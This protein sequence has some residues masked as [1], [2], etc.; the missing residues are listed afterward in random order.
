MKKV[1]AIISIILVATVAK[2]EMFSNL[3]PATFRDINHGNW[4]FGGTTNLYKY[5]LV[6][7]DAGMIK[8]M[9]NN[10]NLF[11]IGGIMFYGREL[12]AK[13]QNLAK[14]SESINFDKNL[15]Q[16]INVGLWGGKDFDTSKWLYGF[17][18]GFKIDIK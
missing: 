9:E 17:Y 16:Y 7:F 11:P 2:A 5:K 12:L 6:S 18:F 8:N 4:Y 1:V 13:N 15:L 3:Q 14:I 10:A